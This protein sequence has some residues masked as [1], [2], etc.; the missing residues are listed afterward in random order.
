MELC[1]VSHQRNGC[2]P[3]LAHLQ[4][5]R[6]APAHT[7]KYTHTATLSHAHAQKRIHFHSCNQFAAGFPDCRRCLSVAQWRKQYAICLS[8]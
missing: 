3:A 6:K 5:K 2:L 7:H 4:L 8:Y 1:C